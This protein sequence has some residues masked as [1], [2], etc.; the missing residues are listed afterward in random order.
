MNTL[1]WMRNYFAG[2]I[3]THARWFF[4]LIVAAIA[5]AASETQ[6]GQS[7]E[8][9][10]FDV[11]SVATLP[12][13][14]TTRIIIVSLDDISRSTLD[15][16]WPWP[17][18]VH[19][20]LTD[21]L[22]TAGAGTIVFDVMFDLPSEALDDAALAAAIH[23][24]GNVV[25]GA[26]LADEETKYASLR[27]RRVPL[28]MFLAAGATEG[29]L[30]VEIDDDRVVRRIPAAPDALWRVALQ[31]LQ[32]REPDLQADF[33]P[34]KS[35]YLRY[36]GPAQ[37][38]TTLPYIKALELAKQPGALKG[39]VVLVGAA[40][41]QPDSLQTPL[42]WIKGDVMPGVEVHAT[43][44][45]N[46]LQR[47]AIAPVHA[48]T[49]W[50][51]T[52][53]LAAAC[54]FSLARRELRAGVAIGLA[55][56]VAIGALVVV[57][58]RFQQMF[59]P[60]VILLAIPLGVL[61]GRVVI[62]ARQERQSR[63]ALERDFSMYLPEAVVKEMVLHPEKFELG[64]KPREMTFLFTDLEGF[65]T[66]AEKH[67]TRQ[68]AQLLNEYFEL[69]TQTVF[70][71][72]GTLDKFIGDAVMAFWG[73]P[74]AHEDHPQRAVACACDMLVT[75]EAFNVKL[76]ERGR[77]PLKMR[78]GIHSG[79]A[80]VGNLGCPSRFCYTALGDAVNV[81]ARLESANKDYGTSILMSETTALG[82]P[83]GMPTRVVAET[84]QV[85]GRK[86][87]LKLFTID[88]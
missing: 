24:A 42:T 39:A 8:N 4:A 64:G 17:R 60:P 43:A 10:A 56:L 49:R 81:A 44:I 7:L 74:V 2:F 79:T 57:L 27:R 34:A 50:L 32:R 18:R 86:E 54:V 87:P 21:A 30:M 78:I 25:L 46:A 82:L 1:S 58:W 66:L 15:L 3:A 53:L 41:A 51:L 88:H 45:E 26:G 47:Q 72:G 35:A 29:N 77:P 12:G 52:A 23:R 69:M 33:L 48:Y 65:T 71:H 76:A 14:P 13:K 85:K 63:L 37:T 68:I 73:A 80:L 62:V 55:W 59:L 70:R 67:L 22:T 36:L 61:L 75:L 31:G 19:A 9:R 16:H 40:S 84:H 28:P 83:P 20:Q 6:F 11:L 38:F 5:L